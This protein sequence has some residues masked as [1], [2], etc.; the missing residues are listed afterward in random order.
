MLTSSP[1]AAPHGPSVSPAVGCR[2]G[3]VWSMTQFGASRRVR[4]L[5]STSVIVMFHPTLS[6]KVFFLGTFLLR[7]YIH[8][9]SKY[10]YSLILKLYHSQ[11]WRRL[12]KMVGRV[13]RVACCVS[14]DLL[15]IETGSNL[16]GFNAI[17]SD[18]NTC[19]HVHTYLHTL[20]D[21]TLHCL[22]ITC[23]MRSSS[24]RFSSSTWI[25]FKIYIYTTNN[26]TQCSMV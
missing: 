26:N 5:P 3:E 23:C 7:N 2:C 8:V 13:V 9:A 24:R 22:T 6:I 10:R 25:Q 11:S 18:V 4:W 15:R 14:L 19:I 21:M 16:Q 20:H 1:R 12:R 17:G